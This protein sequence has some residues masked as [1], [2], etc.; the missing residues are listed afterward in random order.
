MLCLLIFAYLERM[1]MAKHEI[2]NGDYHVSCGSRIPKDGV[3]IVGPN[4]SF[5]LSPA[6]KKNN[7]SRYVLDKDSDIVVMDMV[8]FTSDGQLFRFKEYVRSAIGTPPTIN[9]I[10]DALIIARKLCLELNKYLIVSY[11][12]AERFGIINHVKTSSQNTAM[13]IDEMKKL[14]RVTIAPRINKS[15]VEYHIA[16]VGYENGLPYEFKNVTKLYYDFYL[17]DGVDIVFDCTDINI[18]D[19]FIERRNL[20]TVRSIKIHSYSQSYEDKIKDDGLCLLTE[21]NKLLTT[22]FSNISIIDRTNISTYLKATLKLSDKTQTFKNPDNI[23]N[24]FLHFPYVPEEITSLEEKLEES[25]NNKYEIPIVINN[26]FLNTFVSH[27]K[28]TVHYNMINQV[29]EYQQNLFDY[30]ESNQTYSDMKR[31]FFIL[32]NKIKSLHEKNGAILLDL[33]YKPIDHLIKYIEEN[34]N[35]I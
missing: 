1:I 7:S 19:D 15:Y 17:T 29:N 31:G 27:H 28:H 34:R 5:T 2:S 14:E 32:F 33:D 13:F 18:F 12:I 20:E 22:D 24:V 16:A 35:L 6:I 8:P 23:K 3:R 26:H 4:Y 21:N 9:D 25:H 10:K 11:T 30:G